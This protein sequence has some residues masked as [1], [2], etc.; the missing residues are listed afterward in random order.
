MRVEESGRIIN[1]RRIKEYEIGRISFKN[2]PFSF[3]S[4]GLSGQ[5]RHFINTFFKR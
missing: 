3:E 5:A 1:L 2:S 4:E